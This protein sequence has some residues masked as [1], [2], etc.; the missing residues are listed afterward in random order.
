LQWSIE[1]RERLEK[2]GRNAKEE[3]GKYMVDS[4]LGGALYLK[5]FQHL[6]EGS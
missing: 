4:Q 2:I 1:N 3:M 6:I 5:E